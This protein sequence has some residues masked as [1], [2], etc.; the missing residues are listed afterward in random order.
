[1][2]GHPRI[3]VTARDLFGRSAL[4][5]ARAWVGSSVHTDAHDERRAAAEADEIIPNTFTDDGYDLRMHEWY[6]NGD[7][8]G[9]TAESCEEAFDSIV[10][11]LEAATRRLQT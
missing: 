10:E 7:D 11:A 9:S 2:L 4:D 6:D 1:M 3:D 5:V 8:D